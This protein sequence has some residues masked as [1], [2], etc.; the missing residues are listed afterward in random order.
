MQVAYA[1][2]QHGLYVRAEFSPST[3]D[4]AVFIVRAADRAG[5]LTKGQRGWADDDGDFIA[6][7]GR[8]GGQGVAFL[9]HGCVRP[10]TPPDSFLV[11]VVRPTGDIVDAAAVKFKWYKACA[12]FDI[13][14]RWRPLVGVAVTVA[15]ADGNMDAAEVRVIREA[16]AALGVD[17]EEQRAAVKN[18]LR[19]GPPEGPGRLG[20]AL[21][22]QNPV[23]GAELFM[24]MIGMVASADD[25]IH[26]GELGV[27]RTLCDGIN[28]ALYAIVAEGLTRAVE[29]SDP[30]ATLGVQKGCSQ[31]EA[32]RAYLAAVKQYHPDRYD[33]A[34]EDLREFATS[35]TREVRAAWEAI[36][37]ANPSA[38]AAAPSAVPRPPRPAPVS[39]FGVELN[40]LHW[41]RAGDGGGLDTG[42][43]AGG[44]AVA[45]GAVGLLLSVLFGGC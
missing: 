1:V 34:P 36:R 41:M 30:W 13:L 45:M 42:L 27:I 3:P 18:L 10:E 33:S 15:Y 16:M 32:R 25:R 44:E 29:V 6:V 39:S 8:E 14:A 23:N 7:G 38:D 11:A 19:L 21:L 35:R 5:N 4:D 43:G 37:D 20:P 26:E 17:S 24:A 22:M 12:D 40:E 31:A 2:G 28:P 9:A